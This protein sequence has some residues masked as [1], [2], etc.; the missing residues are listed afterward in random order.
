MK[1]TFDVVVSLVLLVVL[2]PLLLILALLISLE[3]KGSV[4]YKSRRVGL[5]EREI[6]LYK[7]RTMVPNHD[8]S[9][10]SLGKNDPRIT[11]LGRWLRKYK[12]DELPQLVNVLKGD[13]SLVGPRP[14]VPGY[15]EIYKHYNPDHYKMK[16]GIT[17]PASIHYF[18]EGELYQNH[19]DPR[20][21]YIN[22]TIPGKVELDR[23]IR[24]YTLADDLRVLV[25]SLRHMI[26]K[27]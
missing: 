25:R 13:L 23:E 7:F 1:R 10:I 24:Q 15:N 19:D 12:L 8:V 22:R 5:D 2:L 17:S 27:H 26:L 18:H 14:D 6:T 11:P 20:K 3:S 4:F 9:G 21:E 16:P